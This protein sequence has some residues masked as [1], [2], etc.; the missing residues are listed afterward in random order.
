MVFDAV[1]S[2]SPHKQAPIAGEAP[3]G[4]E[5]D[6]QTALVEWTGEAGAVRFSDVAVSPHETATIGKPIQTEPRETLSH[7]S[8]GRLATRPSLTAI[9]PLYTNST[10]TDNC[11]NYVFSQGA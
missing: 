8:Y 6:D 3:P 7:P 10:G 4:V 5:H 9:L 1:S 2:A 11:G